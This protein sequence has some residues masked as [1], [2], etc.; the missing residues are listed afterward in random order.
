MQVQDVR[1]QDQVV[2]MPLSS[3]VHVVDIRY[4]LNE[5]EVFNLAKNAQK[6]MRVVA[7]ERCMMISIE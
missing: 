1:I 4:L 3:C 5:E 7:L 2:Y 6:E